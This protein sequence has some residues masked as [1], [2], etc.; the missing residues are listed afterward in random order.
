M[1]GIDQNLKRAGWAL[2]LGLLVNVLVAGAAPP[3]LTPLL[4]GGWPA[5][6]R[7]TA[8]DVKVVGNRAYVALGAGRLLILDVS[9]PAGPVQLSS[10]DLSWAAYGVVVSGTVAYVAGSASGL[11]IFDVEDPARPVRLGTYDTIGEYPQKFYR[12]RQP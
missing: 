4:Q 2:A 11:E 7:G 5:H 8:Y 10:S 12:V 9:D 1:K 6:G 3:H